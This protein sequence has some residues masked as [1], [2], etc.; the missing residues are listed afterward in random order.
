MATTDDYGQG[1]AISELTDAPD[2]ETLAR[3]IANGIAPRSVMRFASA[4]ARTATLTA[5][6]AGMVTWL[7]DVARLDVYDGTTW[8]PVRGQSGR[9]LVTSGSAATTTEVTTGM[10]ITLPTRT[11]VAYDLHA[12]ALVRSNVAGDRI[13]LRIRR[14]TTTGSPQVGG[15][16]IHAYLAG[17]GDTLPA[18]GLDTP[19]AGTTTWTVFIARGSG[20]GAVET[21][22]SATLPA[23]FT[24]REESA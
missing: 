3:A 14:G 16:T 22:A 12:T 1:I 8:V 4:L 9:I 19:G 11:G 6:A 15:G 13:E 2:A 7:T 10:Q 17:S 18:R 5:P 20:T 23:V 21:T 24:V